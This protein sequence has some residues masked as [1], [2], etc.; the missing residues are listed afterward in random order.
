MPRGIILFHTTH[1]LLKLEKGLLERG[2]EVESIPT[3][4]GLSSDC[5]MALRF[6]PTDA[7]AVRAAVSEL[8]VEIEGIHELEA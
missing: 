7:E 2:L 8:G 5:G 1:A 3:P 6:A 4:R